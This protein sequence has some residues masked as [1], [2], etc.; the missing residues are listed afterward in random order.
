MLT[1]LITSVCDA[2]RPHVSG[3]EKYMVTRMQALHNMLERAL[4][5]LQARVIMVYYVGHIIY[6]NDHNDNSFSARGAPWWI[7]WP[8][9]LLRH[10]CWPYFEGSSCQPPISP[11]GSTIV[12]PAQRGNHKNGS[13]VVFGCK[14][15]LYLTGLPIIKCNGN[16]WTAVNFKC[17]LSKNC[18][19]F[20]SSNDANSW[21]ISKYQ[22]W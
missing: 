3:W 5:S 1:Q 12:Y 9:I 14:Q 7:T 18:F 22:C 6:H 19:L 16:T 8:Y 11:Y 21:S 17:L 20:F 15:G 10:L 13:V 2:E 4:I